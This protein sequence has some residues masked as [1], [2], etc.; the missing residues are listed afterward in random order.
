MI[1][2]FIIL[3]VII[4]FSCNSNSTGSI[5]QKKMQNILWDV[6]RADALAQQIVAKDSTK[7]IS[8]EINKLVKQVF[9][10]YNVTE[11]EFKKSYIY[12]TQHADKMKVMVD[13]INA[14]QSRVIFTE[15]YQK[16]HI[17]FDSA[18][19]NYQK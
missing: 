5:P 14:Q 2:W 9:V 12:Y 13:S 6:M 3:I 7:R 1:K 4:S 18:K 10:I 19:K 8:T 16:R 11:D 15:P 17:T